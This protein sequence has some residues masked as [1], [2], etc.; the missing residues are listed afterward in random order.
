MFI[1]LKASAGVLFAPGDLMFFRSW[2]ANLIS[3]WEIDLSS[4][5]MH[6]CWWTWARAFGEMSLLW[7]LKSLS[8]CVC[9]TDMFSLLFFAFEPF[10]R[11]SDMVW[12]VVWVAE[13]PREVS[14]T[15]FQS[16]LEFSP[17]SVPI[18]SAMCLM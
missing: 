12:T 13:F 5:C 9:I 1:A 8:Q 10:G 6:S 18:F 4:S 11:R 17:V 7:L 15:A 14:L 2:I 3:F 16:S